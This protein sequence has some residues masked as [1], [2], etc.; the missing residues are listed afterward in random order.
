[1]KCC[2]PSREAASRSG[3][4][5]PATYFLLTLRSSFKKCGTHRRRQIWNQ[6]LHG[7]DAAR[8]CGRCSAS[9]RLTAP[10]QRRNDRKAHNLS[11][12][13]VEGW[14][15]GAVFVA[16]IFTPSS[17]LSHPE[18]NSWQYISFILEVCLQFCQNLV[19]IHVIPRE[20][21]HDNSFLRFNL[22]KW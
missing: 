22:H 19:G 16:E 6:E 5:S 20:K 10:T 18:L 17:H 14:F 3:T 8:H 11:V 12:A 1:M 13:V 9:V 7:D 4:I 15:S 21:F 2:H